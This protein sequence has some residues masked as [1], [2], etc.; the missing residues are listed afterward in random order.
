MNNEQFKEQLQAYKQQIDDTINRYADGVIESTK[1]YY[2]DVSAVEADAYLQILRRG[3][4]RI[5]GALVMVGYEMAGGANK[6][7]IIKAAQAIEML[8][9]FFL[10]IDDIQDCSAVRRG[11]PAAH[12]I[13][14]QYHHKQAMMGDAEHFGVSIALNAAISGISSSYTILAGLDV[15]PQLRLNALS[16]V[17]RTAEI[18]AHGQT[19]DIRNQ[20]AQDVTTAD[21]EKVL[22]MKTAEYTMLNPLCVGMVLA[23]AE[24]DATDAIRDYALNSGIAFQI[25]DDIIGTFGDESKTGK[26]PMDDFKEGK[27]TLL[28]ENT[29][30]RVNVDEA[31]FIKS[32]LGKQDLSLGDFE[33]CK[34]IMRDSGGLQ[35]TTVTAQRYIETA[36]SALKRESRHWNGRGVLFLENLAK[37]L[38]QRSV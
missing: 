12:T 7:M 4:K 23:G 37:Y 24:C 20:S 1:Q 31:E 21:I 9:A 11:G 32:C 3:G 19:Y 28:T 33:R 26:S 27:R 16:I 6:Q 35:A 34:Q 36:L 29:L 10:V 17:A 25:T 14:A 18:T 38:A 30:E 5:R 2:G 8:H 22:T 15:E 13:L